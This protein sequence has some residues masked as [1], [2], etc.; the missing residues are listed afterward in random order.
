[1]SKPSMQTTLPSSWY[2][3]EEV[4]S[5]EREHIFFREWLCVGKHD[6]LV[7]AGDS[8]VL[9]IQGE[10]IIL[11]RNTEGA[12]KAFYNVCR[13][14]GA[15]LCATADSEHS[16]LKGGVTRKFI[17]CPYHAWSYNLDGQLVRAP[18]I[19]EDTDFN[20][21]DIQL[22]P[23]GVACW[24]G[25]VFIHMS[26]H[27]SKP[28]SEH[29]SHVSERFHRYGM[30]DLQVACS[31]QYEVAA[32]WK[33]ICENYNECYHCGPVHPELCRLVP[34]FR[35]KGSAG[36]DWDNGIPHREGAT[37]FT[38]SGTSKRRPFPGL[39]ELEQTR[40]FGELIYPN[41]FISLSSDHIA[42][43]ILQPEGPARTTVECHFLF[44]TY[45]TQKP[46]FDPSDAVDF[47]DLVNRQDWE[48]CERVQ[49]GISSRVHE[50]G[51]CAPMEDL[52]LDIREYVKTRIGPYMS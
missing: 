6:D 24:G 42:V 34:S 50:S 35:D 5:L 31:L 4:F 51:F 43:F 12:F 45:E 23:V 2:L 15:R 41:M 49:Q 8:R 13:H 11:L 22:H 25:F 3:E 48:V 44:E 14:C 27:K 20:A 16:L 47:W 30:Q 19:P 10:S 32:N 37:T 1:M 38:T 9:D 21:Q 40:H 18:H 17:I 52:T 36:L 26:P 29:V 46:D 28:F 33:V 39:N 7:S